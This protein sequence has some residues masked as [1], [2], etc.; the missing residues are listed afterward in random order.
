VV[1]PKPAHKNRRLLYGAT[2]QRRLCYWLVLIAMFLSLCLC[3]TDAL[4]AQETVKTSHDY[5]YGQTATFALSLSAGTNANAATLFINI[6][7]KNTTHHTV[8]LENNHS[9]Y[10]WDLRAAPLP[11][12]ARI[13]YWWKFKDAQGEEQ[14]IEGIPFSYIDNRYIWQNA[15][16]GGI[17]LNWVS[18]ETAL[19]LKALDIA[20]TALADIQGILD[21]HTSTDIDIYIYPSMPDLH[22]ALRLTGRNWVGGQA[23]PELGVILLAIP[24]SKEASLQMKRDIPH[25]LTHKVIYDIAGPL[26]HDT[27]PVWLVEGLASHF[28]Q[29]PTTDYALALEKAAETN[30]FLSFKTLCYPF[31]EN[32]AQAIL[33][34]AQSQSFISYLQ[35]TYG[36]SQI[37]ALIDAY[38]NGLDCSVGVQRV[39][40]KDL[41]TLEREWRVWYTHN[42]QTPTSSPTQWA[43][44]GIIINDLAPWLLLIGIICLPALLFLI[45][46]QI[47]RLATQTKT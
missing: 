39:L 40:S 5:T 18:G 13:E 41:I 2:R 8:P 3:P 47:A 30:Q 17:T 1:N 28:E 25:E 31:S 34:Y 9:Q 42:Q 24:P 36:W 11:P 35:K 20:A 7:H 21:D 46:N 38:A 16:R 22:S 19:M 37:R 23:Y 4:H 43:S 44:I 33:S 26:G 14:S 29:S 10:Q 45:Q 6:N 27:L 32:R 12:Y 15:T